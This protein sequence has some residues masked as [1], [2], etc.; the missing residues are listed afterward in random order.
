M[1]RKRYEITP[2]AEGWWRRGRESR[3]EN[4]KSQ[5]SKHPSDYPYHLAPWSLK[6]FMVEGN[7][8]SWDDIWNW[9]KWL[10]S[11]AC[12]RLLLSSAISSTSPP[13]TLGWG[14]AM[15]VGVVVRASVSPHINDKEEVRLCRFSS[16]QDG[17]PSSKWRIVTPPKAT[18]VRGLPSHGPGCTEV[19]PHFISHPKEV[20]MTLRECAIQVKDGQESGVWAKVKVHGI[21]QARILEWVAFPFSRGSS[22]PKDQTQVSCVLG[23]FFTS[24][25]TR[26][27]RLSWSFTAMRWEAESGVRKPSFNQTT[28][29]DA[30]SGARTKRCW[31]CSQK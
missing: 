26:E 3:N 15:V 4:F 17:P 9:V 16:V 6:L 13:L 2:R 24:W 18:G 14:E 30:N 21:L 20:L 28:Q 29:L 12:C 23:R 25:A 19:K 10:L 11:G 22:Q 5:L 31:P 27:A 7:L 8:A 1:Q